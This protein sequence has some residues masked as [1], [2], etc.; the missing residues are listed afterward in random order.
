MEIG[1]DYDKGAIPEPIGYLLEGFLNG[2]WFEILD[3]LTP[4]D[5][6][7]IDYKTFNDVK[8][9]KV[10]IKIKRPKKIKFGIRD[11]AVFGKI[12]KE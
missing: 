9:S 12:A 7:N 3:N 4:E 5:E 1:L 8:C 10:R 6:R 2:E 11:F